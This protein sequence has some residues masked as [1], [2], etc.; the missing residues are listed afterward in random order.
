MTQTGIIT[1]RSAMPTVTHPHELTYWSLLTSTRSHFS[2]AL[3]SNMDNFWRETK[4]TGKTH[5]LPEYNQRWGW[6]GVHLNS[7]GLIHFPCSKQGK[8]FCW[9]QKG[10]S[11][12]KGTLMTMAVCASEE[13]SL[14]VHETTTLSFRDRIKPAS[15][16]PTMLWGALLPTQ[17]LNVLPVCNSHPLLELT[18]TC[19]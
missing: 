10:Y 3:G 15:G 2:L 13:Q 7:K 8:N 1:E 18:T 4:T 9:I 6:M 5:S 11:L 16:H 12:P 19:H 14:Q 17:H